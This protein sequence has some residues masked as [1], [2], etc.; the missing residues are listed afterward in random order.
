MPHRTNT[1]QRPKQ[2]PSITKLKGK[3]ATGKIRYH[4]K[5]QAVAYLHSIQNRRA[6]QLDLYTAANRNEKRIYKC[7]ECQGFHLTSR[8]TWTI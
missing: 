5:K 4:D 1:K 8:A 7:P 6:F 2:L 3:C